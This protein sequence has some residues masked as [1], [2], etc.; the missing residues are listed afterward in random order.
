VSW[1]L[2]NVNV[3]GT[4]HAAGSGKQNT[5]IIMDYLKQNNSNYKTAASVCAQL[6]FDGYKD[7]FL[8]S[9]DELDFMYKNLKLKGL[10]NLNGRFYLSSSQN[11]SQ[12]V[13]HQSFENGQQD[14]KS[15]QYSDTKTMGMNVRAIRA[16]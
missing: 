12:S 8:P 16:F 2:K 5:Q 9:K 7:W 15:G 4:E 6:E 1:G 14:F 10:G 3:P 13:W 11:N